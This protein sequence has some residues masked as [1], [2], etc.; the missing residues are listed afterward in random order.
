VSLIQQA[1][2]KASKQKK[3]LEAHETISLD[4]FIKKP[5]DQLPPKVAPAATRKTKKGFSLFLW[6]VLGILLVGVSSWALFYYLPLPEVRFWSQSP[7][8]E[9]SES[10]FVTVSDPIEKPK[11]EVVEEA[12]EEVALEPAV[13]P[14][15][16]AKKSADAYRLSGIMTLDGTTYALVNDQI[17][18]VGDEVDQKVSVGKIQKQQVVLES[19]EEEYI[20]KL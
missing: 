17:L 5:T 6:I 15:A 2:D 1:L 9:L 3:N 18:A 4:T 12:L 8:N 16:E 14:V 10:V 20:L 19:E 13:E 7:S 11:I